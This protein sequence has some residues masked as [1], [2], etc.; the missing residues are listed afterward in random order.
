M[1]SFGTLGLS[2]PTSSGQN[3][4]KPSNEPE[5]T[6]TLQFDLQESNFTIFTFVYVITFKYISSVTFN[7]N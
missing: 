6:C 2:Q 4:N 7:H 5:L 1:N 3:V